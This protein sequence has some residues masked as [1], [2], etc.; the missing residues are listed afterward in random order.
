MM[1]NNTKQRGVVLVIAL[2]SLSLLFMLGSYFLIFTLTDFK[3]S[4]SQES[5]DAAYYLAEAGINEAIWK[6]KNDHS[7]ED[8][9]SAWADDF[10]DPDKN[11]VL[12]PY[13]N[14]S[15]SHSFDDGNYTVSIQNLERGV[16]KIVSVAEFPA[17]NGEYAQRIVRISVFRALA[18]PTLDSAMYTGGASADINISSSNITINNGNLFCG[19]VF[20]VSSSNIA[21]KDNP[22]TDELEGKVLVSN[23]LLSSGTTITSEEKCA[24]NICTP[25]CEGYLP[26]QNSCPPDSIGVPLVDFNSNQPN[27][28]KSRAQAMENAGQCQILCNGIPCS[29]KCV[30]T[31]QQF[32]S[33]LSSVS[34]GQT[35]TINSEITYVTGDINISSR[36]L[37]VNGILVSERDISASSSSITVNQPDA[38]APSG[39][40]AERKINFSSVTMDVEGVIYSCDEA[41]IS[42]SSGNIIGAVLGRK[43]DFS[44]L[45]VFNITLDND[46]I[47][48]GLGY[49]IDGQPVNPTFS[50]AITIDHW[51]ESY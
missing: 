48:K 49:T 13:W 14:S 33:L 36:E 23:N 22:G 3:I 12:G 47:F 42:S 41:N 6:L 34:A 7:T 4:Q 17:G 20:N 30:F 19:N 15:F 25:G 29:T 51:E 43:L 5:G 10:I 37:V 50:P 28:F 38:S 21:V 31:K 24:K 2:L 26:E 1:L 45:P 16:G 44:S 9:D 18:S 8:G 35:I 39:L 27:S 11:P 46:I 32:S 40:I